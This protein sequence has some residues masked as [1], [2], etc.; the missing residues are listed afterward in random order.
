MLGRYISRDPIGYLAGLN[1]Y[2]YVENNLLNATDPM[3]LWWKAALSVVAGVAAA[4]VVVMTAPVSLPLLA[5]AAVIGVGVG[6]GVNKALNLKEFCLSCILGG[7]LEGFV[8][9][10]LFAAAA[11]AAIALLPA[12]LASIAILGIAGVS[13]YVMLEEHFDWDLFGAD[14]DKSF[15]EMTPEEQNR[16]LGNLV[17]AFAGAGVSGMGMRFALPRMARTNFGDGMLRGFQVVNLGKQLN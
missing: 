17:G 15:Y 2:A 13:I 8:V 10:A 9:G 5:G 4:A 7:F 14:E 6:L 11:I 12:T 16:S 3:G 1:V